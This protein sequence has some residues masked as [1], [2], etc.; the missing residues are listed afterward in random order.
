[1]DRFIRRRDGMSFA[2]KY[3]GFG[4][5]SAYGFY[6]PNKLAYAGIKM[7]ECFYDVDQ[8]EKKAF[9]S[10]GKRFL[11]AGALVSAASNIVG[12]TPFLGTLK[13]LA[14]TIL[15][16]VKI[17]PWFNKKFDDER[18]PQNI[19]AKHVIR[20]VSSGFKQRAKIE[21]IPFVAFVLVGVDLIV[22]IKRFC[23]KEK[24]IVKMTLRP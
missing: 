15:F 7:G 14:V 6:T 5:S 10:E 9:K 1:M 24:H 3:E 4:Q 13:A 20:Q 23:G 8:K 21:S 17:D 16:K 12:Y 18:E 19:F 22:T 11:L 2:V